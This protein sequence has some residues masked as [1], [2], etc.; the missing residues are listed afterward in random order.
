M[1]TMRRTAVGAV[2]ALLGLGGCVLAQA[3]VALEWPDRVAAPAD[4]V[5]AKG[6]VRELEAP[7]GLRQWRLGRELRPSAQDLADAGALFPGEQEPAPRVVWEG[8]GALGYRGI[9]GDEITVS[10]RPPKSALKATPP[11]PEY[12]V[13]V[14]GDREGDGERVSIE[15]TW[16]AYM[17]P[18]AERP[19]GIAL[20]MPGL[21]GTPEPILDMFADRLRKQGWGV[22]RMVAQ[23]SR[24][25][26]RE[27]FTVD[28]T[29]PAASVAAISDEMNERVAEAAF[30]AEAAMVHVKR[31]HPELP[32]HRV[33]V[34]MSGG[35]MILPTVVARE[36]EKYAA[37]V[38]IA[39][40]SNFFAMTDETNYKLMIGAVDYKW[41]PQPP[42]Q[43]QRDQLYGMYLERAEMDS[44]HTARFIAGKPVLMIHGAFDGAV[45]SRLGDLLWEQLGKPER[46]VQQGG[47]EEVFMEL[48]KRMDEI[49]AWIEKAVSATSTG[50]APK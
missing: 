44:Y 41:V 5:T 24:F 38:I 27:I 21:L 48:P 45:P 3:P 15:R 12:F 17:A 47:H 37:S 10:G 42:T 2:W 13:F 9:K 4:A 19:R 39:G 36:P 26:E 50:D 30:A 46:W 43:E 35:G 23:P 20:L 31:K 14:S 49:M 25:T 22:V 7:L 33:A 32:D 18:K 6:V 34:G 29:D 1:R 11:E 40:G 8:E 28:L 16:F